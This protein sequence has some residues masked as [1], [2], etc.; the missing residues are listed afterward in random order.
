M[1]KRGAITLD[2]P[3]KSVDGVMPLPFI[4]FIKRRYLSAH[5]LELKSHVL[6]ILVGATGD[7]GLTRPA[8]A[9]GDNAPP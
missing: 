6:L 2:N 7:L 8:L 9:P 1:P 4:S 5:D 3:L